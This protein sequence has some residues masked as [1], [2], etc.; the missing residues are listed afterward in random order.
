M[1]SLPGVNLLGIGYAGLIYRSCLRDEDPVAWPAWS[2]WK[3][4]LRAGLWIVGLLCAIILAGALVGLVPSLFSAS[5][6]TFPSPYLWVIVVL[7]GAF[8]SPLMIARAFVAGRLHAGFHL[9]ALWRWFDQYFEGY[10]PQYGLSSALVIVAG[11]IE[12]TSFVALVHAYSGWLALRHYLASLGT[13]VVLVLAS[14][15]LAGAI[16]P[17]AEKL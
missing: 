5:R 6:P 16:R 10:L 13:F 8:F 12:T 9:R 17:N 14:R 7:I 2:D 4:I 3:P 1:M 11:V 15:V